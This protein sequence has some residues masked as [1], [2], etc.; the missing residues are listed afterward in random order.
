MSVR[1]PIPPNNM[2]VE[3]INLWWNLLLHILFRVC[4]ILLLS[5][6]I[7]PLYWLSPPP[8]PRVLLEHPSFGFF[9]FL[10]THLLLS[11]QNHGGP[12]PCDLPKIALSK[13]P[14]TNFNLHSW[15]PWIIEQWWLT[16]TSGFPRTNTV[17][18]LFLF[19]LF[20]IQSLVPLL[21]LIV[22]NLLNLTA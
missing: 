6:P 13:I 10:I 7:F 19:C 11:L 3:K 16:L 18:S 4:S 12:H 2:Q 22:P 20:A 17:I 5:S 8:P 9:Y 14:R 15:L 21:F 1:S